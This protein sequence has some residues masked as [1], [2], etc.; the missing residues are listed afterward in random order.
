MLL[1]GNSQKKFIIDEKVLSMVSEI[2]HRT[3]EV[4]TVGLNIS[5]VVCNSHL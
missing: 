2:K 1:K 3:E 5:A 4:E